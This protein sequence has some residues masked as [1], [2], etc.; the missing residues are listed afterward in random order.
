MS[1]HESWLLNMTHG[2]SR[3]FMVNHD[4]LWLPI[5][6]YHFIL[7][8]IYLCHNDDGWIMWPKHHYAIVEVADI[9]SILH[10]MTH[11]LI[12]LS[13][14]YAYVTKKSLRNRYVKVTVSHM[15]KVSKVNII[16]ISHIVNHITSHQL[17][18]WECRYNYVTE[19]SLRHSRSDSYGMGV[20]C[21]SYNHYIT[22]Y[23]LYY[24]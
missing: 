10:I 14:P 9:V 11:L 6:A 22:Y 23:D 12:T 8:L 24:E 3:W 16:N 15:V 19:K 21:E 5:I 18:T 4:N 13:W 2:D 17:I 7:W 20:Y 1:H